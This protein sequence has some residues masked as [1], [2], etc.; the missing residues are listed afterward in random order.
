[1]MKTMIKNALKYT[2]KVNGED[3]REPR[4]VKGY[5]ATKGTL[6][7]ALKKIESILLGERGDSM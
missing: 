6:E 1:M 7:N 4:Y 3:Y 2:I 5:K